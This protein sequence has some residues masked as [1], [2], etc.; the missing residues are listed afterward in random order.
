MKRNL[1]SAG[2]VAALVLLALPAGEARA[3]MILFHGKNA[4][5]SAG[6]DGAIL[7]RLQ[8]VYG[9]SNVT[10]MQGSAAA[11]DGSSADGYDAVII[12]STINSG[13]GRGKYEDATQGVMTWEAALAKDDTGDFQ[14]FE[15]HYSGSGQTQ[16]DIVDPTH[17]LAAGLSGTV[18]V[19]SVAESMQYGRNGLGGGVDLV[20]STT[21]GDHAILAADVGDD[22]LGD[23]SPVNPSQAAG[24]RVFFFLHDSTFTNLTPDGLKLFDAAVEYLVVDDSYLPSVDAGPDM[25]SWSGS[26]VQMDPN[27][28]NNDTAEP[29]GTL[30]YL[31]T[32]SP[33]GIGDPNLDVAITDPNKENA[34]VTVTKAEPAGNATV[35][36]MT[37]AV[38][39]EGNDPVKKSMT[40]DVYDDPCQAAKAA[41]LAEIDITDIDENCIT[42]FVDF[43]LMAVTWL[44]DYS[45]TEVTEK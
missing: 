20:A 1:I 11:A 40:I 12:S 5:A 39:L 38:T 31:W 3:A 30:T 14:M 26:T 43:A 29:K 9:A 27:V 35:V 22:L 18:T 32:A 4:T 25:I 2:I 21:G 16:V 8:S 33:D 6:A 15:T 10:Y 7:T 28:V 13:D 17:P 37:L 44:E 23:G 45:L 41:G 36:T 34:T 24:R 19:T 42:N